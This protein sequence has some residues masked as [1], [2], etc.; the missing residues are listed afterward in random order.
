VLVTGP[1][2]SGKTTTLAALVDA[3]NRSRS[4]HVITLE[5]PIEY[6]HQAR[7]CQ[8]TQREIGPHSE[9]FAAALRGALRQDPDVIMVGEL[10]DTETLSMAIS[11]SETG[12]LVLGTLH[13]TSAA[14]TVGRVVDAFPVGSNSKFE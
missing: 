6:V 7:Q 8:I 10:R 11:A 5:Q 9:S 3:V 2:N 13:T 12:H 14:S 1:G 4:D